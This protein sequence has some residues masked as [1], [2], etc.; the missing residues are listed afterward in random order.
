MKKSYFLILLLLVVTVL[1]SQTSK[2]PVDYVN[3]FIGTQE[4]GHTY[5]GASVPFGFVQLSPD[6]DTIPYDKDGKYNPDVYRYCSGYQYLDKTIVGFSHTHFNGTG[7]SDLGDFLIMPT[8]G[9]LQLNPGTAD[10]PEHGYRSSFRHETESASPGYY[11]VHLDDPDVEA[12][13]TVTT[14][15]GIHRYTFPET[16]SAHII[17]DMASGIYNY[18]GKVLWANV[19]VVNDSIITG[20][21]VT[22][23]WGRTRYL[24][25]AIIFS[26]PFESF[27]CRNDEKPVYRGFW[28][29]FDQ[30]HNFPE[31]AGKRLCTHFD[32]KT[33]KGEKIMLRI[34]LSAVS[35]Q[36]AMKN[37]EAEIPS[38]DF[39]RIKNEAR[40]RWNQEL[41]KIR[42][43]ATEDKKI[44]F[45]TALYHA[46][47]A[48]SIYEDVDG[49]YRGIDQEIHQARNFTNYTTFSLWDTHRALHP[50]LTLLYPNR[51]SDMINSML[52]H[53]DQ[54]PE[55][56]LPIWSHHGNENWC[57][58]GYHSVAVIADAWVKGVRGFDGKR[59]LNAC[60]TTSN[61]TFY[62]GIGDYLK[63][64]YVPDE[65]SG[66]SASNTLEYAYD[67]FTIAQLAKAVG[68][69]ST[70][71]AYMNRAA[72]Y[73]NLF[74]S[75][76]GFI[77]AK[78]ST[79]KWKTP[80]DP[81]TTIGQGFIEGNSWN[82]S[83][84]VPH[85]VSH[86]IGM[87]GG[88]KR[89]IPHLDS[90]F[91]MYLDDKYFKETEDLTR[92]GIIG[93]Y[94]HGNEPSHHVAYL[95][96]WTSQ[97]WKTQEKI[98]MILRTMYR[99]APN[100]LCGNDDCGQMS[101]WYIFSALGFYPVCPG[102]TEYAIGAPYVEE[103]FIDLPGNKKFHIVA[104]NLTEKNIYIQKM[105]LNG[106]PLNRFF[107]DH[108]DIV[109]GGEL[110]FEMGGR[111]W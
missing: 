60:I 10:H 65:K 38:F 43:A 19:R 98:P 70:S 9:K 56:M 24:Y 42:I 78:S 66:S 15:A 40:L 58:T 90:L 111:N 28:R 39:D 102:T 93:N 30:S 73:R 52:A 76:T 62:D 57:M 33:L 48:P 5:P 18:D 29:R 74:D 20:Y 16:D 97:P 80:F 47:L 45:Y 94:V 49:N 89:F 68:E 59:A 7:H 101:A 106:K 32:F 82:Y 12:E 46:L 3:P 35:M 2:S 83:F 79:G 95:Y 81:L 55:K 103:A 41:S 23:G 104:K 72:S 63:M 54:S 51:T 85:D 77:R 110:V 37:L 44:N 11:R 105:T 61:R 22:R 107:I 8:V 92:D 1:K 84:Y 67:D 99:N 96:D 88:E 75:S 36:G 71:L 31:M 4:M 109:N 34:G 64:G 86:Y 6:T 21:R 14:R 53:F 27:G 26:K 91:T 100:G 69:V 25:F 50:L 108:K 13:M 87:I 17:L